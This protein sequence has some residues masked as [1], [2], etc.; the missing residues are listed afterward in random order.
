MSYR[1]D[2]TRGYAGRL[3]ENLNA[4]LGPGQ[5]FIDIEDIEVGVDFVDVLV[6][7]IANADVTLVLIGPAWLTATRADGTRRLDDPEDYVRAELEAAL[8]SR[9]RIVPVLLGGA[10]MPRADEL[11]PTLTSLARRNALEISDNRWRFDVDRL[12][13]V[14][15]GKR[16]R[17]AGPSTPDPGSGD[18]IESSDRPAPRIGQDAG[19]RPAPEVRKLVTVLAADLSVVSDAVDD[20][21]PEQAR[22]VLAGPLA[23]LRT[24]CE[25]HGG[26]VEPGIGDSFLALFG[27]PRLHEDDALRAMRAASALQDRVRVVSHELEARRGPGLELRVGVSS[28]AVLVGDAASGGTAVTGDPVTGSARLAQGAAAGD[29]VMSRKTFSLVRDAVTAEPVSAI[30]GRVGAAPIWRLV[31][32]TVGAAG[33]VRSADGPFLGRDRDLRK[34]QSAWDD[35]REERRPHLFTILGTAGVGKSRLVAE[36]RTALDPETRVVAGTCLSYGD[37][38]TY[39]P[40]REVVHGAVGIVEVDDAAAARAR[41]DDVLAAQRDGQQVADHLAA[42]IGLSDDAVPGVEIP[43]AA[44]T[45]LEVLARQAPLIV[46]WDDL[47][48]AEPPFLQLVE[49]IAD[50]ARDVPLM[51]LCMARPEF[52]DQNPG[53]AGG[54]LAATTIL[55]NPLGSETAGRLLAG[56]PGGSALPDDVQ[57]RIGAAAEGNPLYLE[58]MLRMLVDEGRLVQADDG[59]WTV[60]GDLGDMTLPPTIL[61]LL[62]SRLELLPDTERTFAERASVVGRVF[63]AGAIRELSPEADR[64]HLP[65]RLEGLV[66]KDLVG[67]SSDPGLGGDEAY[68]FR[69]LLIRDAAYEAMPK[70]ER[71]ALHERVAGWLE[72]VGGD[73]GAEYVEI[74]AHHLDEAYRYRSLVGEVGPEMERLADRAAAALVEAGTR[75]YERGDQRGAADL[76]GA[77]WSIP[78]RARDQAADIFAR[79]CASLRGLRRMS[80]LQDLVAGAGAWAASASD[81][82]AA[83]HELQSLLLA[84]DRVGP[85]KD[86]AKLGPLDARFE[87]L[88]DDLGRAWTL[89]LLGVALMRQG[90]V[91]AAVEVT[92]AGIA[93]A[94]RAGS[95]EREA[96]L[97]VNLLDCLF[98]GPA[99]LS[100]AER[101][102]AA[103]VER[104]DLPRQH[105]AFVS[106]YE[107][108]IRAMRGDLAEARQT[109]AEAIAVCGEVDPKGVPLLV[110]AQA[111]LEQRVGSVE[112]ARELLLPMADENSDQSVE[113][114]SAAGVLSVSAAR[115]GD[116]AQAAS[117][118]ERAGEGDG[119]DD[120]A[121]LLRASSLV[122]AG[123][124]RWDQAIR[125]AEESVEAALA[126]DKV[127]LHAD[128]LRHLGELQRSVGRAP[129]AD[130]PLEVALSL[131]ESKGDLVS[132]SAVR[133]ILSGPANVDPSAARDGA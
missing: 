26:T 47:Q 18:A 43:W 92:R 65:D 62:A 17:E 117:W 126:A 80:E 125:F 4:R 5:V 94:A 24:I 81:R 85:E 25:G 28:G 33:H 83:W 119:V 60:A 11:P 73:R 34:L 38:I 49:H 115:L 9:T 57:V 61:G 41:L 131:Y 35:V 10:R 42:A 88:G 107:A 64:I 45:L 130:D 3:H 113:W 67:R 14:I 12:F 128:A 16:K 96:R 6:A 105:R 40:L 63:E 23:E 22:A 15:E 127:L 66:R 72:I 116:Y 51:L 19:L 8:A 97:Q 129:A 103:M 32:A 53:W 59:S 104:P 52:L 76:L 69:H 111:D 123:S 36:F 93:A 122:A 30:T 29:V 91:A 133:A 48:W 46:I 84:A 7:T 2:D 21:D 68:R 39:W 75:A 121:L 100:E 54:K 44:R 20:I 99:P 109:Y 78:G 98:V 13:E 27:I 79:Y 124:E 1:R 56:L 90:S 120:R 110:I 118:I 31:G 106:S 89:Q 132:A 102:I 50:L 87:A 77:A 71:A 58:E 55:L 70:S 108:D 86:L 37:G 101:E 114:A 95:R 82:L 112:R 74:V